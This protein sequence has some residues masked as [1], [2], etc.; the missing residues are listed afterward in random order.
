M[1]FLNRVK[2][3]LSNAEEHE[4][5]NEIS[6]LEDIKNILQDSEDKPQLIYKH[7]HRCSVCF[8][9]K[10]ELENVAEKLNEIADLYMVNVVQ[11]RDVS[12]AIASELDIRHESPQ[13][14]LLQDGE[15]SWAGSH[16]QIKGNDILSN[17][18]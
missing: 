9:A 7:S 4:M 1:S 17:L 18:K 11:Q 14:L 10:E 15:V 12:N 6:G 5:W 16:W 2:D 13:V 8:L 3:R